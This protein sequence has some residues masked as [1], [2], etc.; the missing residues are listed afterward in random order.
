MF[1]SVSSR[2][3]WKSESLEV[4][5]SACADKVH[6]PEKEIVCDDGSSVY[7]VDNRFIKDPDFQSGYPAAVP[8]SGTTR[9]INP[10]QAEQMPEQKPLSTLLPPPLPRS[11][12]LPQSPT[13]PAAQRQFREIRLGYVCG[14]PATLLP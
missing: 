8:N 7:A 4:R 11:A 5:L 14:T 12:P 13:A 3:D 10:L 9:H 6:S 1:S 2:P